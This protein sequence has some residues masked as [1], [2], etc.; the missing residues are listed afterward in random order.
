MKATFWIGVAIGSLASLSLLSGHFLAPRIGWR[1]A[2]AIGA[3]LG[4]GVLILRLK[5]PESPRWLMLRGREEEA[6]QI[7]GD[8][9]AQVSAGG[10]SLAAVTGEK[11]RIAVQDHM[12]WR[13]I[14]GNMLG[15]IAEYL[16]YRHLFRCIL[17]RERGLRYGFGD[18]S[19]GDSRVR[20]RHLLRYRHPAWRRRRAIPLRSSDCE[21]FASERLLWL[22][23]GALLM[24]LAAACELLIGVEAA[25]KSL[26]SISKPLQSR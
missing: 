4:G 25:G 5:V 1:V 2:F 16:L 18:L 24:L 26:E 12:L 19:A 3:A 21:W 17:S 10:R 13:D 11:L 7:V 6:N 20:D 22:R 9:E 14:F 8:I 15:E 23:P